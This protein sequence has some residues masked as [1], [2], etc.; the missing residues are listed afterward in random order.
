M[1]SE[2]T[3]PISIVTAFFDI[4]RGEIGEGYPDYLRRTNDTYF[5]HFSRLAALENEMVVFI[6]EEHRDR[7]DALREG[8]PTKIIVIELKKKFR[9]Q[10]KAI[11]KVQK[12]EE[13]RSRVNKDMLINNLKTYFVNYAIRKKLVSGELVAWVDF[14]YIRDMETLNGIKCWKYDF[15][16]EKIHL[17]TIRKKHPLNSME[18][19]YSAIF[20]NAV[21]IIGGSLVG[22]PKKWKEFYKLL[23]NNQNELLKENVI[24]DD[25][26]LYMMSIFKRPELFKLNYLGKDRWFHLFR[27]YDKTIKMSLF[28][29]IKDFF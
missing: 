29:R 1:V 15:D 28:E 23:R 16:K 18:D 25:Q 9:R 17:F 10:I 14:G 20:N 21:Y 3:K 12:S 11:E 24:D 4:G 2:K 6:S 5:E 22:S 26:G 8:K 7:I 13:F 19:V 27:K